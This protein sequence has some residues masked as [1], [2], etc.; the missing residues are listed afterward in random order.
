MNK[1][2]GVLASL[3]CA[4]FAGSRTAA[5]E[6][7][8]YGPPPEW[9]KPVAIPDIAAA[10]D[11]AAVQ[12]LLEDTQVYFGPDGDETYT[13]SV[14]RLLNPQ[15]LAAMANISLTWNPDTQTLNLHRISIL[16]HGKVIDLLKGGTSVTVLRRE[17]DL[18]SAMLNGELTATIQPEGLQVGD[19]LDIATTTTR[20]DPVVQGR[21][22]AMIQIRHLGLAGRI[23]VREIWPDAKPIRWRATAGF[24]TPTLTHSGGLSE[25][26]VDATNV[27]SPKPP[28]DAPPRY[29]DVGQLETSQFQSWAEVSGLM[30][31]LYE[32]ATRLAPNAPLRKEVQ[33]I[34]RASATPKARAE[35]AL[36]LVEDQVHYTFLGMN[37]G[38]YIPADA[39]LTWTRRFGD[40]KG[41]TALLLSLLYA[42][43]I[44]A[45]PALVSTGLGDGLDQRLPSLSVFDHVM[46]RA[47]ING[48]VYWLDGTRTGDRDLDQTPPPDFHWVLPVQA[49]AATLQKVGPPPLSEPAFESFVRLDASA[50]Y[51]AAAPAHAEHIFRGDKAVAWRLSL[52][53]QGRADAER[54]LREYWRGKISWIEPERVDYVY[55]DQSRVLRM[56]MEGS[57]RMAWVLNGGLRE[58]DI[59]DSNLGF[60]AVFKREPDP[61]ADAPFSVDFPAYDKWTV[62][63][64]LPDGGADFRL[65]GAPLDVDE[66]IAGRHYV[67]HA[68]LD[69]GVAT[70]VAEEQSLAPEFPFSEADAAS[71]ALREL[72]R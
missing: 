69:H 5:A 52:D 7:P 51:E 4:S 32:K 43:G 15:A 8:L 25:L 13:E 30:A 58:F 46:V 61:D 48:K 45:Q 2:I 65:G 42:L 10:P 35:A 26:K 66:T 59:A 67:R 53:G 71:A 50:G 14:V 29:N 33:R 57:A 28:R 20:R 37:F 11:G 12:T 68:R 34:V 41:K 17:T 38:G 36:R 19:V 55:D 62:Q 6:H 9:M 54:S 40:C 49:A 3:F 18:E 16:R 70:M 24:P 47:R 72:T 27:A 39:D 21:S 31:P 63:I 22:E 1:I 44:D 60:N 56:T 23:H 64:R